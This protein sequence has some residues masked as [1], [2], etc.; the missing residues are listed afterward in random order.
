MKRVRGATIASAAAV[1]IVAGAAGVRAEQQRAQPQAGQDEQV[2]CEGINECAGKGVCAG[3]TGGC[4][5]LNTCRGKGLLSLSKR[6]CLCQG[7]TVS[8]EPPAR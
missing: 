6:D 4:A 5:G 7:G 3:A 1:L 2:M 8:E